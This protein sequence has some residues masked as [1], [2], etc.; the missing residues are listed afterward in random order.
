MCIRD[1]RDVKPENIMLRQDRFVRDRIVKVLDF[2]LAKLTDRDSS[3]ADPEAVTIPISETNPGII[4]GTSGYMSPEQAQGET[5]DTRSDVFS[6]GVVLYEMIAGEPPFKGRTDSHTRVSIL[7]HE[8]ISLLNYDP[9][10]PRQLE[11]IVSKALAKDRLKRYQTITV[12]KLVLVQLRD[13]LYSARTSRID[14]P[15]EFRH[16]RTVETHAES[17]M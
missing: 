8:P 1:S 12:L 9:E 4:M 2:G 5:I 17:A 10:T 16:S 11:R 14:N 13:E 3:G 6:L 15:S 7:D